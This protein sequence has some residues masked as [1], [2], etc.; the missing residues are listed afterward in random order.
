[1]KRKHSCPRNGTKTRFPVT[2]FYQIPESCV[3]IATTAGLLEESG[4][5]DLL[6]ARLVG[7]AG[8]LFV[9]EPE[10]VQEPLPLSNPDQVRFDGR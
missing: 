10:K 1:M 9:K 8:R 5:G 2:E 6:E 4:K 3:R 7:Q